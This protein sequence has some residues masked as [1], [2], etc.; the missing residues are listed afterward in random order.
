MNMQQPR[1]IPQME[2]ISEAINKPTTII[3]CIQ[4]HN[5]AEF[6]NSV[7]SSVYD[8]VDKIFVI[9]GAVKN[10]PNATEDGHSIDNTV[11]IINSFIQEKDVK[12]KITFIQIKRPWNNL[13]E[14]KQTFLDMAKP[15]DWI[16]INDCLTGDRCVPVRINGIIDVIPLNELFSLFDNNS[17]DILTPNCELE[18]L[19]VVRIDKPEHTL[20]SH[21][22]GKILSSY[23]RSMLKPEHLSIVD[24]FENG[25]IIFPSDNEN[26][27]GIAKNTREKLKTLQNAT[28][29]WRPISRIS[30][31]KT[32]KNIVEI[33]QKYGQV[34]CTEDH[35]VAIQ[36]DGSL[37]F[38]D[39]GTITEKLLQAGNIIDN[40]NTV[41]QIQLS[42]Y[43]DS[44]C[45][46]TSK[47]GRLQY[48]SPY[49]KNSW[50]FMDN[51]IS[52]EDLIK[53]CELLGFYV[54]EGSVN[55]ELKDWRICGNK[56]NVD[57]Y[58][59]I[60]KS[61]CYAQFNEGSSQKENG[62]EIF[63]LGCTSPVIIRTFAELCGIGAE[64]K[65]VPSMIF[66][67]PNEYKIAFLKGYNVGDGHQLIKGNFVSD[68]IS[69]RLAAGICLLHKQMNLQYSLS[70]RD[71][72]QYADEFN[73]SDVYTVLQNKIKEFPNRW[74]NRVRYLG[75]TDEYVYDITVPD[76]QNFCDAM[77]MVVVHNCDEFYMPDDIR[78]LR[79]AINRNPHIC[80]LI[81]TFLHFYGDI[82]TIAKPG[83][84]WQPFHQRF[85][86][87]TRGMRYINHPTVTDAE[88]Y[89]T[90]FSPQYWNRRYLMN[91]FFIYHYGY[92]RRDMDKIM[93]DKQKYYEKELVA[94]GGAN[95]K[96]DQKVK[97]WF[98]NTE[99]VLIYDGSHPQVMF[100][101][102]IFDSLLPRKGKVVGNWEEDPFYKKI[103]NNQPCGSMWLNQTGQANPRIPFFH[104]QVNI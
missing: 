42:D 14:M 38:T 75:K 8:E 29:E 78:R 25:D 44:R 82:F 52:G 3:Q 15:G 30:R 94:H 19:S 66:N 13:E 101:E 91:D 102:D 76:T 33:S 100:S 16:L 23:F 9:E 62:T 87:Y 17:G 69:M 85:F 22:R 27:C 2:S 1:Y 99:P 46:I 31:K 37:I 6:A 53:F 45:G 104:N 58:G 89:D 34:K 67:L 63:Y 48:C 97:D 77:G 54:A 90:Y 36:S 64:N 20:Y 70:Y 47:D 40:I 59:D 61:F 39:A 80:E 28:V 57:K 10:R 56:S 73:H 83:P 4:M 12:K 103:I 72:D 43:I 55:K 96:F 11:E 5:E 95:K 41:K 79:V 98:N 24:S 50:P 92:A 21:E 7:L 71:G 84:E 35:K 49:L 86:K 68:T 26:I 65:K 51:I 81:P 18:T 93:S 88:G 60:I 74:T 32:N